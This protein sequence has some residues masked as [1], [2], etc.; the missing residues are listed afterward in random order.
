MAH[1]LIF[2]SSEENNCIL[3]L[4]Y[5]RIVHLSYRLLLNDP[6]DAARVASA[7]PA[8]RKLKFHWI[9]LQHCTQG[10]SL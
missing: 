10:Y 7:L 8:R 6:S 1:Q 4:F 5:N 2:I 3:D 9:L